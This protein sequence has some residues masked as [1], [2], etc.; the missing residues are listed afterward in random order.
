MKYNKRA[1]I[2]FAV[3]SNVFIQVEGPNRTIRQEVT[4][5][6]KATQKLVRGLMKFMRGEFTTSS[7]QTDWDKVN[8]KYEAE[9]YIPC[10]INIGDGGIRYKDTPSGPEPD[11]DTTDVRVPPTESFW[12]QPT[13]RVHFSDTKLARE[14]TF[15][16]RY[17]IGVIELSS[18]AI[19][20][21]YLGGDIEQTVLSTVV[22]PGYFSKMYGGSHDIYIT[23][24]GLF[25]T[26]TFGTDDLLARVILKDE[27]ELDPP[28]QNHILYVRPQ[29]TIIINWI[30]S[31]I[32]LNDYNEVD[33]DSPMTIGSNSDGNINQTIPAGTIIEDNIP[34]DGTVE[35]DDNNNNEP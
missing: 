22:T 10:Y 1:G 15:L 3:D 19:T 32:S 25:A 31:I 9:N 14:Q 5:H 18:D 7:R 29:D 8:A 27:S 12:N 17:P 34:Y 21:E 6:N 33:E 28:G 35:P 30:I 24:L 20:T 2:E 16:S 26:N 4:I 13:N 23:E 11:Y